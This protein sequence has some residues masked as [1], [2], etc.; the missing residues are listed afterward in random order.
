[1]NESV[2]QEEFKE[3][4]DKVS[5]KI[6][7]VSEDLETYKDHLRTLDT[8]IQ[9]HVIGCGLDAYKAEM[10]ERCERLNE[11][12]KVNKEEI[13]E[14]KQSNDAQ[15]QATKDDYE[16]KVTGVRTL[17]NRMISTAVVFGVALM[18]IFGGIN[19]NKVSQSEFRQHIEVASDSLEKQMEMFE[20]FISS[21][22][23][24]RLRREE[25]LDNMFTKQVEFNQRILENTSLLQQ[26]LEVIKTRVDYEL[27][28][29]KSR[30]RDL[31]RDLENQ[32]DE[33]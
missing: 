14:H 11:R 3:Y 4:K 19:V 27:E 5:Y 26:Q 20:S 17:V 12:I 32:R 1:M 25:K 15:F 9:N 16:S 29:E 6:L 18:G 28:R 24:D 22:T 30:E 31:E 33:R 23:E 13:Q 8:N 7:K 21:Y 2:T 10:R